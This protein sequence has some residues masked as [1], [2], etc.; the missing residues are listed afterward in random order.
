M[1]VTELSGVTARR[2]YGVPLLRLLPWFFGFLALYG[3]SQLPVVVGIGNPDLAWLLWLAPV[4]A[5]LVAGVY[6]LAVQ[7]IEKR[8]ATELAP[9]PAVRELGLGVAVGALAFSA[10][11]GLLVAAGLY[12]VRAG[13]AITATGGAL[14][15]AVVSGVGEEVLF[16]GILMR[17]LVE[18]LGT[19]GALAVSSLFFGA[20]HL[21]NEDATLWSALAI[22]VEAGLMLGLAFVATGRLWLPI[23]L[24]L[25]WNYV[26]SGIFGIAV[27]GNT[28]GSGVLRSAPEPGRDALTGGGFGVE[29]SPAAL[30]VC[31]VVSAVLW[32][33]VRRRGLVVAPAWRRPQTVSSTLPT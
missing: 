32:V 17:R 8:P 25:A 13:A 14:A 19:Y 16:R 18:P 6:V 9:G 12:D 4:S 31:L 7:R 30:V 21:L 23:G 3:V 26:Q 28:L 11:V 15:L 22:A 33:V 1:S 5:A 2:R 29:A 10:A 24:H 20:A 27:S